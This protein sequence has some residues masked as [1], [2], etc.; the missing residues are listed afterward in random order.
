MVEHDDFQTMYDR[1]TQTIE[2]TIQQVQTKVK[3]RNSRIEVRKLCK[4]KKGLKNQLR[5]TKDQKEQEILI[6]RIHLMREHIESQREEAEANRVLKIVQQ[7]KEKNRL[8]G[9]KIW[10]IKRKVARDTGTPHSV[11]TSSGKLME[12]RK[13]IFGAYLTHYQNLLRIEVGKTES[14]K[15]TETRVEKQ[16]KALS[17]RK[18]ESHRNEITK[19]IVK[20]ATK[21]MRNKRAPDRRLESRVDK[22]WRRGDRK[23]SSKTI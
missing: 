6:A 13:D 5:Q 11:K 2:S 4:I 20:K 12:S 1:W 17:K 14:E 10:E 16:F 21:M 8:Y 23:Q 15:T 7:L 19:E 9:P 3:K 18:T 22:K